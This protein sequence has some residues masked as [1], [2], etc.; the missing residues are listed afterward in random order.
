M[1]IAAAKAKAKVEIDKL[2]AVAFERVRAAGL[3]LAE[4]LVEEEREACGEIAREYD[5][6]T[7]W[8]IAEAIAARKKKP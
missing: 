5:D 4:R 7:G 1:D 2:V 3:R 6:A 8:S